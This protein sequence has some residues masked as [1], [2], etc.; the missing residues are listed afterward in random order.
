MNPQEI[1]KKVLDNHLLSEFPYNLLVI[2]VGGTW[3]VNVEILVDSSKYHRVTPNYD[4]EYLGEF[5]NPIRKI[6]TTGLELLGDV[7]Y[8]NSLTLGTSLK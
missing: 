1:V 8:L 2:E 3:Y 6:V 5:S 4:F 7:A